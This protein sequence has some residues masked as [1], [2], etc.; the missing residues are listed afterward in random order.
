MRQAQADIVALH[1]QHKQD[2]EES[3]LE[4]DMLLS[5]ERERQ[6]SAF[7]ELEQ[8]HQSERDTLLKDRDLLARNSLLSRHSLKA[9]HNPPIAS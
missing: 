8:L 6:V 4:T 5:E 9:P 2:L 1:E 3:R 7:E